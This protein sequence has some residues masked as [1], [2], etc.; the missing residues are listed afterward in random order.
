MKNEAAD[1]IYGLTYIICPDR[2]CRLF[3][4]T[5]RYCPCE[6]DCPKVGEMK[7]AV[8]CFHCS[9]ITVVDGDSPRFRI[10]CQ[11]GASTFCRASGRYQLVYSQEEINP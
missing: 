10:Q 11:C 2:S 8:I 1:S 5:S 9:Q 7:K 4:D 3:W 6:A